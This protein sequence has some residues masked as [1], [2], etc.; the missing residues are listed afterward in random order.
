MINESIA[1]RLNGEYFKRTFAEA[2]RASLRPPEERK[3]AA[4]I[5]AEVTKKAGLVVTE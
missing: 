1:K 4:N 2:K 3:P 5:V